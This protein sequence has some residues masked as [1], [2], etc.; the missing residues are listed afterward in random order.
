MIIL[1]QGSARKERQPLI[2]G[3]SRPLSV[4]Q[5]MKKKGHRNSIGLAVTRQI[6]IVVQNLVCELELMTVTFISLGNLLCKMGTIVPVLLS[7]QR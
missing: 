1:F 7:L 2:G 4:K 3:T 6:Y 5:Q